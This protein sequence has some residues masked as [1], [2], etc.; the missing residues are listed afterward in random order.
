MPTE[1][2][3]LL[4]AAGD[5]DLS[6]P[7][8]V[9]PMLGPVESA[10][11]VDRAL[12]EGMAGFLWRALDKSGRA[13]ILFEK[14]RERL[15]SIYYLTLQTN[16]RYLGVLKQVLSAFNSEGI[17]TAVIQGLSLLVNLYS[18][19][20]LRPVSDIDLWVL[21]EGLD[22]AT[23]VLSRL[24]FN[25]T[26]LYPMLF[27]KGALLI[28]LRTHLLGAER[29]PARHFL[30]KIDQQSIFENCRCLVYEGCK[31][32]Y[33]NPQ[34]QAIYLTIHTVKHN[35]ERL[36]WLA[37]LRRLVADWK[38]P[39]WDAF[40]AR[41]VELGQPRIPAVTGYLLAMLSG[42]GIPEPLRAPIELSSL[43]KHLLRMRRRG[44]LPQWSSLILLRAG[45]GLHQLEFALQSIFPRPAVLRQVFAGRE[46]LKEWQLYA[47]RVRQL[48]GML[49]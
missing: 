22:R 24:G 21:P 19:P 40:R 16:L 15:K 32:R 1:N 38:L 45:S 6:V 3:L 20:G 12:A 28:D 8:W 2:K 11:L 47:L 5:S 33:L 30:V 42:G 18:D 25:N 39:D 27:R 48:L 10:R 23:A 44:P 7:A 35:L 26:A 37:D 13:E 4:W 29:I 31:L 46:E 14:E 9:A 17:R 49:R 36:V 43:E 41:A 34:D